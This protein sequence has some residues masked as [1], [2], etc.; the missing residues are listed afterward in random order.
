MQ[1]VGMG[2]CFGARLIVAVG[3]FQAIEPLWQSMNLSVRLS[4]ITHLHNY[5]SF[6]AINVMHIIIGLVCEEKNKADPGKVRGGFLTRGLYNILGISH[7]RY[8][9]N[10]IMIA[11]WLCVGGGGGGGGG[12]G[13]HNIIMLW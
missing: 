5:T 2:Q 10:N 12:W 7:Y 3:D 11:K 8:Y 9:N 13:F 4:V 1:K 6:Y